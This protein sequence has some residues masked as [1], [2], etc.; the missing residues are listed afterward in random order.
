MRRGHAATLAACLA[1]LCAAAP[2]RA[3]C[4]LVLSDHRSGTELQRLPLDPQVPE[5]RIAFVHSV[6]GTPVIDRYRFT[7]QARLVEERFE[8]EGYGLPYAAG[9]GET[10]ARSGAGWRL[11]LDRPVHPLV[12]RPLPQQRMRL[13]LPHREWLLGEISTRAIEFQ[14]QGCPASASP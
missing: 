2:A 10:L 12:V 6:L 8:G 9:P 3:G 13:L 5:L 11:Q 4:E 14:A 7:P 1:G